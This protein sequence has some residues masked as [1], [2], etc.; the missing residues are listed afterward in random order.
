MGNPPQSDN[1]DSTSKDQDTFVYRP[2]P[3]C[4]TLQQDLATVHNVICNTKN[5]ITTS[6]TRVQT[7]TDT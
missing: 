2:N 6:I 3:T 5:E 1:T 7:S 4:K